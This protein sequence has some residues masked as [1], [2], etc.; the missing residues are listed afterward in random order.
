MLE[1]GEQLLNMS[2]GMSGA[3]GDLIKNQLNILDDMTPPSDFDIRKLK[4]I[5]KLQENI[6]FH[7]DAGL[8]I[9]FYYVDVIKNVN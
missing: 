3:I 7:L 4:E 5:M 6:H 8:E 1:R 9:L 2:V